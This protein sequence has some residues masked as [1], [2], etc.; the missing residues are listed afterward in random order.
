MNDFLAFGS[1]WVR[2]GIPSYLDE[3][4]GR[5]DGEQ[6]VE[7][8]EHV[9]FVLLAIAVQIDL[10]DALDGQIFMLQRHFVGIGREFAG[11]P[12]DLGWERGGEQD[13]LEIFVRQH[14]FGPVVSLELDVQERLAKPY[15][16]TRID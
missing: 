8:D 10:F 5:P 15:L 2:L 13:D 9:E 4:D 14:T 11:K 1:C 12:N 3:D 7:F 16:L 6:P